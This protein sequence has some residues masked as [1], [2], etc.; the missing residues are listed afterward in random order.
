[1]CTTEFV[2]VLSMMAKS[3]EQLGHLTTEERKWLMNSGM[4]KWNTVWLLQGSIPPFLHWIALYLCQKSNDHICVTLLMD[5]LFCSIGLCFYHS[6]IPYYLE[7]CSFILNLEIRWHEYSKCSFFKIVLA[8]LILL[9]F[10]LNFRNI[11]I[12]YI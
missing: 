9:P 11:L 8:A 4:L 12:T 10:H 7:Y 1:M 2:E 3:R 5:F 6:Q